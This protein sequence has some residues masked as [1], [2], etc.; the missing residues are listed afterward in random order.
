MES[1]LQQLQIQPC[2]ARRARGCQVYTEK[3]GTAMLTLP[4][5]VGLSHTMTTARARLADEA[6]QSL[7]LRGSVIN[8]FKRTLSFY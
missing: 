3:A 6:R 2:Y 1:P 7:N 4:Y 8:S 5:A